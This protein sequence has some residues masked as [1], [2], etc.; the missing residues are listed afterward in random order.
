MQLAKLINLLQESELTAE[1]FGQLMGVSGMTLRRWARKPS[2]FQIP[3]LYVPAIRQVC[4]QLISES[5]V[6]HDS[7]AVQSILKDEHKI[8]QK[9]ALDNLG[10]K[11]VFDPLNPKS[12]KKTLSCLMNIG[13]Q[14]DKQTEVDRSSEKISSFKKLGKQWKERILFLSQTTQSKKLKFSEKLV[15]YGALFYLITPIDF[16]PDHVPAFGLMDD[17]LILGLALGYYTKKFTA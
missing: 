14:V 4:Y 5:R 13:S 3:A 10:V 16:I 12:G 17:F 15:A 9:A 11:E 6:Q 8:F 2:G 1:E 7:P